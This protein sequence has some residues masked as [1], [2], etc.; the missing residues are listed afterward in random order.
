MSMHGSL[1]T[2]FVKGSYLLFG[3]RFTFRS[4]CYIFEDLEFIYF[5]IEHYFL[6]KCLCF[7]YLFSLSFG[8]NVILYTYI[9]RKWITISRSR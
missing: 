2:H 9:S 6:N 3:H 1:F 5:I 7:V 8:K 4:K